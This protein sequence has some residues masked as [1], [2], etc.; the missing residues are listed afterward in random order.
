MNHA[1]ELAPDISGTFTMAMNM[2]AQILMLSR[3]MAVQHNH[4]LQT[5]EIF[6]WGLQ[7]LQLIPA[8]NLVQP[9]HSLIN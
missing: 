4:G 3:Q 5:F 9:K 1:R 8:Q 7:I 6:K 2:I